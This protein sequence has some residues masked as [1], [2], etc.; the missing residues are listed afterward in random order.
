MDIEYQ[1][2]DRSTVNLQNK[3][4]DLEN[5]LGST[6][7]IKG[8]QPQADWWR[9]Y[10]DWAQEVRND[11]FGASL[12]ATEKA[13]FNKIKLNP[14]SSAATIKNELKRQTNDKMSWKKRQKTTNE[15]KTDKQKRTNE[16]QQKKKK[17]EKSPKDDQ[18]DLKRT[19]NKRLLKNYKNMQ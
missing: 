4:G 12:T 2:I 15:P 19:N 17:Q 9:T 11:R 13:D 8:N 7:F 14:S 16:N 5:W 1:E 10:N 3:V 6:G 18:H